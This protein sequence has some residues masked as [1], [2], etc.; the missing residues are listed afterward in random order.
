MRQTMKD[1]GFDTSRNK[2]RVQTN[3]YAKGI[4]VD[5]QTVLVGSH[6]WTRAGIT[7]NR[8]ASLIFFDSEIARYYQDLFLFDLCRIGNV[9]IDETIPR[10][11]PCVPMRGIPTGS[12]EGECKRT[13]G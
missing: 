9:G 6:N 13:V 10:P 2:V 1:F 5:E 7:L 11:K 3:C 4:I 12:D 8:D